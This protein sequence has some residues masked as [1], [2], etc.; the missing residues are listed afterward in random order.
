MK[1]RI[2]AQHSAQ[3]M[4]KKIMLILEVW[5]FLLAVKHGEW[6]TAT[7]IPGLFLD[8]KSQINA[9]EMSIRG[10]VHS[11]ANFR[12]KSPDRRMAGFPPDVSEQDQPHPTRI[13]EG[14]RIL[15]R[16]PYFRSYVILFCCV[17]LNHATQRAVQC[18]MEKIMH[19][20]HQQS[21]LRDCS[22]LICFSFS[23]K[24]WS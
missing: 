8:A 4:R 18:H 5:S 9:Q 21:T 10:S 23:I 19:V 16:A 15:N 7:V 14:S 24:M 1:D 17:K 12:T 13:N 20:V 2:A 11:K 22:C 3:W 6:Q